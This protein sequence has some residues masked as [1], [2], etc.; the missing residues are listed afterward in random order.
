M[1]D[2]FRAIVLAIKNINGTLTTEYFVS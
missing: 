2:R 1:S